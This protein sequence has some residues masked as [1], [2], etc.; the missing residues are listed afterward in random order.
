G[1][2]SQDVKMSKSRGNVMNPF[3]LNEVFGSELLRYYLMREMVF[4]QDCNFAVDTVIQRA[5]SDLANDLGNL[6][7]RTV[8][9]VTKYRAGRVSAPG[10]AK[11]DSEVRE[12]AGRVIAS[13]RANFDD[14]NFSR[15][16]ENVWELI[17][18]VNKY[19]VENETWALA[20]KPSEAKKPDSV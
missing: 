3:V 16:L 12:L 8:A 19:I 14:Y 10:V 7:S 20:E 9:M 5:N 13:Y 11:G 1:W 15:G 2:L 18:R 6:L 4:G 17:S